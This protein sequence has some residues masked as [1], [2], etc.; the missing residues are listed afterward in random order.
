VIVPVGPLDIVAVNV[1]LAPYA[2]GDP[3]DVTTSVGCVKMFCVTV[4]EVAAL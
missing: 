2:E 4:F 1:T 3:D